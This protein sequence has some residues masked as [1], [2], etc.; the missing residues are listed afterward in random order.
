MPARPLP[1]LAPE[2]PGGALLV[3]GCSQENPRLIPREAAEA[4]V[5]SFDGGGAAVAAGECAP[6]MAPPQETPSQAAHLPGGAAAHA[7]ADAD[8]DADADP[9]R[10]SH[11]DPDARGRATSARER[12]P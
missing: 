1:L 10:G 4:L 11:G 7:H 12:C 8:G 9:D 5:A 3:P 2:A 6:R